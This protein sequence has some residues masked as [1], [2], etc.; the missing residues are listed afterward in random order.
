M[1]SSFLVSSK[2]RIA[3][4]RRRRHDRV[5]RLSEA[6]AATNRLIT[7]IGLA[8][9]RK[10]FVDK[11]C[12][13]QVDSF[14]NQRDNASWQPLLYEALEQDRVVRPKLIAKNPPGSIGGARKRLHHEALGCPTMSST[15][16]LRHR[17]SRITT[18]A[19]GKR[20]PLPFRSAGPLIYLEA[21][22]FSSLLREWNS[23]NQKEAWMRSDNYQ[24]FSR[25]AC[26]CA[27]KKRAPNSPSPPVFL[28]P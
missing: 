2:A 16:M 23:S 27:W 11:D 10:K 8:S 17:Q 6:L 25:S 4:T 12:D 3:G 5:G 20:T 14:P 19:P 15:G 1:I 21:K 22:D 26:S 28:R 13:R 18:G 9:A 24:I 7:W